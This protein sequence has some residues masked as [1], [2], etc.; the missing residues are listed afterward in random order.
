MIGSKALGEHV[1][2]LFGA[3]DRHV[4][5]EPNAPPDI[6]DNRDIG[7]GHGA[8][9]L[10]LRHGAVLLP[11]STRFGVAEA[12]CARTCCGLGTGTRQ[13]ISTGIWAG[14]KSEF[15]TGP[16]P[17]ESTTRSFA[18]GGRASRPATIAAARKAWAIPRADWAVALRNTQGDRRDAGS[19][20][21]SD[22][23]RS[24]KQIL[25]FTTPTE[26]RLG[27][28]S[29]RMTRLWRRVEEGRLEGRDGEQEMGR[30]QKLQ[31]EVELRPQGAVARYKELTKRIETAARVQKKSC[32]GRV[33]TRGSGERRKRREGQEK[34]RPLEKQTQAARARRRRARTRRSCQRL[35]GTKK[36]L[37]VIQ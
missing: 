20:A 25:R 34:R 7:R 27:P 35:P 18:S 13:R 32:T 30:D 10:G 6:D 1:G 26:V 9:K 17:C 4:V 16:V 12:H 19:M 15:A 8:K 37:M 28:R 24:Q 5:F 29:L 14:L 36:A 31:S 3:N 23:S 33:E 11:L 21:S 22:Q 2:D